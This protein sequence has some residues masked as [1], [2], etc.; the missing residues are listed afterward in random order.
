M[1]QF[2]DY[3]DSILKVS[4]YFVYLWTADI[5][6]RKHLEASKKHK[7][8][9]FI[10]CFIAWLLLYIAVMRYAVPYFFYAIFHHLI[11]IACVI[12]FFRADLEKKILAAAILIMIPTL[13]GTFCDSFLSC[14]VLFLLHMVKN[15]SEPFLS[16]GQMYVIEGI[17]SVTTILILW[18]MSKYLVPVFYG[19]TRKWY[20]AL[21][22]PLLSIIA[23]TEVANW[24]ASNGIMVKSGGTMGFYYDQLFSHIQFCILA[25]LCLSA[26]GFYIFGMERI[27]LEQ[28]KNNQYSLQIAAYKALEK[29]YRESERLRHDLKN[30]MNVLLELSEKKEW[31]KLEDYLRTMLNRADLEHG[32]EVTGNRVIDVLLSQN[33][34][35][36]VEKDI[37]WK[38]DVRVPK[39]NSISSF[40]LCV[41][42]GNILDNA[43]ESCERLQCREP[44]CTVQPFIDVQANVVKKCFLLEV[45]NSSD[46]S[47]CS[48]LKCTGKKN[49]HGHG[50]GLLNI[51]DVVHR[52]NGVM[53]MELQDNVFVISVLIPLNIP[54]HD[55][56]QVI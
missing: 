23:V 11:L 34:K 32:E 49:P 33:R 16:A 9:F 38:C 43:V 15:I 14:L 10:S 2:F 27:S 26:A 25:L 7:H 17:S 22:L 6:C 46:A 44:H 31:E 56:K 21:A 4:Y 8:L 19:K 53:D 42:F 12:L 47:D 39:I 13:T 54:V 48:E 51:R 1:N 36:A 55:I 52:Y 5:F 37:L 3:F 40:D 35:R 18:R 20:A 45:K 50:I 29:Q 28:K 24:G 41:L 30:H